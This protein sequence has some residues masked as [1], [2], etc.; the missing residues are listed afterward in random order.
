MSTLL[1]GPGTQNLG[2]L[3]F[4]QQEYADRA[5]ASVIGTTVFAFMVG[6]QLIL[7]RMNRVKA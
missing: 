5:S 6:L 1:Y 2:V 7:G 4:E 3:L